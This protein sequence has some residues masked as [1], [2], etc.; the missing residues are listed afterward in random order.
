MKDKGR[1]LDGVCLPAQHPGD[2]ASPIPHEHSPGEDR[3]DFWAGTEVL[4][5]RRGRQ[6][7]PGL[8]Q[9]THTLGLD[10]GGNPPCPGAHKWHH[11]VGKGEILANR[12]ERQQPFQSL[13]HT[14]RGLLPPSNWCWKE[15]QRLG[16]CT[17]PPGSFPQSAEGRG[18]ART[19]PASI[20]EERG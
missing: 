20:H 15:G 1:E 5:P 8:S 3:N 16:H 4:L 13:S 10:T 2:R 7:P 12:E 17:S 9:P 19:R 6:K 18:P 11:Q 14:R